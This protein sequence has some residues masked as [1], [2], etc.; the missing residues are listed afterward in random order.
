MKIQRSFLPCLPLL[1]CPI[2]VLTSCKK[3]PETASWQPKI[4]APAP[5]TAS[6]QGTPSS[7]ASTSHTATADTKASANEKTQTS[8]TSDKQDGFCFMAYNLRNYLTMRRGSENLAKPEKEI[9][10]LIKHIATVHPDILGV[11]EIGNHHDLDDLSQRL[12][13]AGLDYPHTQL[14]EGDDKVR[15][16]AILSKFPFDAHPGIAKRY[17]LDGVSRGIGRGVLDITAHTPAG[18]IR[19]L[20]CHLKSKR[21]IPEADQALMRRHEALIVRRHATRL[22][23]QD[24]SLKLLIYGDI[25]DTKRSP[26]VRGIRG[27]GRGPLSMRYIHLEAEDGTTWTHHWSTEDIYSRIDFA[28][29]S[30]ALRPLID[31]RASYIYSTPK[32]CIASDHRPLIIHFKASKD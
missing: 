12:R 29:A 28:F 4:D 22:L 11:C 14:F 25:N 24:Q 1:L 30:Q 15:R 13:V 20:G 26:A 19:F 8:R 16:L 5:A 32:G 3:K 7:L 21:P 27:P 2:V 18:D 23:K 17:T 6:K 9:N 31:Q 10:P